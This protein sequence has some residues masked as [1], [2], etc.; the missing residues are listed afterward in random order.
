[1]QDRRLIERIAYRIAVARFGKKNADALQFSNSLG[2][3][4]CEFYA[5]IAIKEVR[6]E[7]FEM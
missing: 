2:W 6:N 4:E 5:K 3:K 7:L 1:M